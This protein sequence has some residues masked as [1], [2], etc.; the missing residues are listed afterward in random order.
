MKSKVNQHTPGPW[1]VHGSIISPTPTGKRFAIAEVFR[2]SIETAN[3]NARLIAAAPDLLEA[4][5][6]AVNALELA[7]G[8]RDTLVLRKLR[9][10]IEKATGENWGSNRSAIKKA[11]Q[12]GVK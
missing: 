11:T 6:Q 7:H 3:A 1:Y 8:G 5:K 12:G 9:G 2:D 4:C 10:T